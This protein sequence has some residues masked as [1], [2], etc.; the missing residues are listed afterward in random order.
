MEVLELGKA[1]FDEL[2]LVLE[3]CAEVVLATPVG[4]G[5]VLAMAPLSRG[6]ALLQTTS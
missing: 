6:D 2:A 1:R 3:P 4:L 5:R